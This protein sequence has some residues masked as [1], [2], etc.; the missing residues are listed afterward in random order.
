MELSYGSKWILPTN[1]QSLNECYFEFVDSFFLEQL[2]DIVQM[3][4]SAFNQFTLWINGQFAFVSPYTNYSSCH[5]YDTIDITNFL[6]NGKN[7]IR[8]VSYYKKSNHL[9]QNSD[10]LGI[11][12]DIVSNNSCLLVSSSSTLSRVASEYKSTRTLLFSYDA[13]MRESNNYF[14]SNS[15][16]NSCKLLPRPT[17]TPF[18]EKKVASEVIYKGFYSYNQLLE[19]ESITQKLKSSFLTSNDTAIS[20]QDN[21]VINNQKSIFPLSVRTNT[22]A[23][24]NIAKG[25]F[26]TFDLGKSQTGFLELDITCAKDTIIYITNSTKLSGLVSD[27]EANSVGKYVCISGRNKITFFFH[28]TTCKYITLYIV[29]FNFDIFYA[30]IR[31]L[32]LPY[33]AKSLFTSSDLLHNKIYSKSAEI[34]QTNFAHLFDAIYSAEKSNAILTNT[35][36]ST[37][38]YYNYADTKAI[39]ESLKAIA[40][41]MNDDGFINGGNEFS[42]KYVPSFSLIWIIKWYEYIF[43]SGDIAFAGETWPQAE[44]IIRTFWRNAKGRD[45]QYPFQDD[46]F[47]NYYDDTKGLNTGFSKELRNKNDG[48]NF[49]GILSVLYIMALKSIISAAKLIYSHLDEFQKSIKQHNTIDFV[50]KISWCEMLLNGAVNN[51]HDA[52]WDN[53][54]GAY[55][56]YVVNGDKVFYCELM[57]ALTLSAGL[58]PDKLQKHIANLLAE[59]ET[60]FPKLIPI[61][62][63][64]LI[65]KYEALLKND[66]S[67]GEYIL[68]QMVSIWNEKLFES[69]AHENTSGMITPLIVYLKYI[70]GISPKLYGFSDYFFKPLKFKPLL[71]VSGKIPRPERASLD[72][73]IDVD[74]FKIT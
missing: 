28:K 29:G 34:L 18:L 19:K 13:S 56:A 1:Y 33:S 65:Y 52:F 40:F 47:I 2:S 63:N 38:I 71:P 46:N 41:S 55:C 37:S 59:K 26:L 3:R 6:K 4:V 51:F 54:T 20:F 44:T 21:I 15:F 36:L 57:N 72:I 23:I 14:K 48:S 24:E 39:K 32:T 67:Y 25:T 73:L 8:I 70:L 30:G 68:N 12:F 35:A 64:N 53:E 50:E 27:F 58:V 11:I 22:E 17:S 60:L 69:N 9:C 5:F 49:D 74:R 16:T 31:Q 45:L 10:Y 7:T 42:Y 43:Y 61:S 66:Y 62:L